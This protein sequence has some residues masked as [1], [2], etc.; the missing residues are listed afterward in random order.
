MSGRPDLALGRPDGTVAGRVLFDFK[1]GSFSP[2]HRDDLRLYALMEAMAV[3]PPRL[4]VTYYLDQGKFMPEEVTED[5]LYSTVARIVAGTERIIQ[6]RKSRREPD[7]IPGPACRWCPVRPD[8]EEGLRYLDE[9]SGDDFTA[10]AE[11]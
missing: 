9:D 1:T 3:L 6:L 8:C 10:W 7:V 5:L 2:T 4:L 11:P